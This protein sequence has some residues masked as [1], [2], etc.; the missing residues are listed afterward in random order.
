MD[1]DAIAGQL[2]DISLL[3]INEAVGYLAEGGGIGS[4]E[5]LADADTDNERHVAAGDDDAVWLGP[6]DHAQAIGAAQPAHCSGGCLEQ[7]TAAALQRLVDQVGDDLGVGFAGEAVAGA[8]QFP[9]QLFV[10][11][12]DAV[13][14]EGD[15]AAGAVGM[16]VGSGDSAVG[17]PAGVGDAEIAGG[18]AFFRRRGQ[19]GDLAHCFDRGD[20]SLRFI[21][22][23]DA[24]GVIAA[25]FE[26]FQPFE[27]DIGDIAPGD[28]ADYAAHGR[29]IARRGASSAGCCAGGRG[30]RRDCR[31][32][33]R[34]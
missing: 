24:G 18:A 17:R 23:S 4:D 27:E 1:F 14:D 16:G 29:I 19:L 15:A 21:D 9:A 30:R 11:F 26:P 32:A 22:Q 33:L 6:V 13:V 3:E 12:D 34:C 31:R 5:V 7:A 10:V 8:A 28:R 25:V 2:R 20:T